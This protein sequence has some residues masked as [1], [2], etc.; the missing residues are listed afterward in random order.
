[1]E[2]AMGCRVEVT[3]DAPAELVWRV[4]ADVTR[5]SEWSHE[6][7]R[8]EWLDGATAAAPGVRFRGRNRSGVWRW[9]RTCVV[10]AVDPLREIAWRTVPTR[11]FVDSTEWSI[12]LEPAGT[13]TRIVQTYDVTKCPEWWE[14]LVVRL[15]KPHVDRSAALADD[16]PRI[17]AVAARDAT[18]AGRAQEARP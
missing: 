10:I 9:S 3:V 16:L 15:N 6:C 8:V 4:V 5:T 11:L 18:K 17:G 13:R 12:R 7:N 1:M 2:A 14:W